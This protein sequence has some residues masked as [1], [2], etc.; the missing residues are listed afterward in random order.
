MLIDTH[1]HL[2]A[3]EFDVDRARVVDAAKNAG[4]TAIVNPAVSIASFA[5]VRACCN[6]F[7]NCFPAYGIHP[8]FVDNADDADID[9]VGQWIEQESA[10]S[11]PPIAIGEIGFDFF[12][13]GFDLARQE[14][15]FTEQLRIARKLNLPVLL[16]VRRSVDQVL[17]WLRRIPV[18]G[19]I[20]HAF[21]GSREQA[22]EFISLGFKLG[23]GGTMT[24]ARSTR[25]REL[26]STLPINAIVLETDA[27]DIP[28]SWIAGKR[29]S[30]SE[31]ARIAEEFALLRGMGLKDALDATSEN[32]DAILHLSAFAEKKSWATK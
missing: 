16:H 12:I 4:V 25:I 32:A 11:N 1:C 26:A 27:P 10:G 6:D 17:K 9:R 7:A 22:D 23:F 29:N 19:G 28:P 15:F 13:P 24:Y 21:N 18:P 5:K 31:L 14:R 2:D 8:L 20:A 30:P 3:S